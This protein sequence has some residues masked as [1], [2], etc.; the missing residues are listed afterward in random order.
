MSDIGL[1]KHAEAVV[2]NPAY[3]TAIMRVKARIFEQWQSTGL[4]QSKER[5]ELW[6]LAR[7]VQDFESEMQAMIEDGHLE[8]K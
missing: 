8:D 6:R 5:K 4:F 2:S 3:Q 7:V 1:G